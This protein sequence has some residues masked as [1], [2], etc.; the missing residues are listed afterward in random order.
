V[1]SFD[2]GFHHVPCTSNPLGVKGAGEAGAVGAPPAVINAV[3]DAL[4]PACGLTHIDM[5][6]TRQK[7]WAAL[8]G[9]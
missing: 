6:A 4:Q 8:R 5:P 3:V 9:R 1:P 7:V 2:C